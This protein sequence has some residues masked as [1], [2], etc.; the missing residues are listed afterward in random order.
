MELVTACAH[1]AGGELPVI[2][3]LPFENALELAPAAIQAGAM[4]VSLAPPR[5]ICLAP[6][7]ALLQGRLYGPAIFPLAL[8]LVQELARLGIPTIGAGGVY[9]R[10]QYDI[11][12]SLGAM[13]VQIDATLWKWA[14]DRIF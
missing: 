5:G 10:D 2:L 8:R 14:G 4:A 11:M 1:A 12:L 13:A 6:G 9:T 7:G 3:R